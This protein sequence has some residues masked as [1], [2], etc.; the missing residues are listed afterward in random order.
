MYVSYYRDSVNKSLF[1]INI[2]INCSDASLQTGALLIRLIL[3]GSANFNFNFMFLLF[4][5]ILLK[6]KS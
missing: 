1:S 5:T 6:T 3:K 2:L 4:F